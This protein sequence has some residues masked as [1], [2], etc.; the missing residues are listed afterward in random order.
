[1]TLVLASTDQLPSLA[2]DLADR[3]ASR[4]D[5]FDEWWDGVYRVVTGPSP[6]HQERLVVLLRFLEGLA[7]ARGLKLL[8]GVNLGID[9]QDTRTPDISA[10]LPGTPRMSPAFLT[11]AQLVVEILS[12]GEPAGAKLGFYAEWQVREYLEIAHPS[13]AAR[14]LRRDGATWH[15]AGESAVL[16]FGVDGGAVVVAGERLTLP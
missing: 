7:L 13:G 3:R 11:T 8:P 1:M 4:L 9:K 14:L 2:Q 6:E 5:R 12:P 10:F 15:E 16:G